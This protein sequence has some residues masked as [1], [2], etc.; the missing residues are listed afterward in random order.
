MK[1]GFLKLKSWLLVTVMGALG[2]SS[3]HSHKK[4]AEPEPE[5]GPKPREEIRLMYGV[6]T[7]NY[8]IRGQVHDEEGRPV[9]NVHVNVLEPGI[10]ATADTVYGDPENVRVYLQE[11]AAVTDCEGR[12]ELKGSGRPVDELRVLV[13]DVDGVENGNLYNELLN[14]KVSMDDV[15]R[16]NANN[17]DR[18]TFHKD[19]DI[20]LRQK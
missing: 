1:A 13:R 12:F 19:L 15:D 9:Q 6:P 14:V 7:M 4:M 16:T 18:G 11:N 10:Q 2:L 8:M 20:K 17:W 3:C 5:Q